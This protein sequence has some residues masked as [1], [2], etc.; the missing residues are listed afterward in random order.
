MLFWTPEAKDCV[1]GRTHSSEAKGSSRGSYHPNREAS[2]VEFTCV[3]RKRFL[4]GSSLLKSFDWSLGH[5][6][7]EGFP[8]SCLFFFNLEA[9]LNWKHAVIGLM[10]PLKIPLKAQAEEPNLKI[11]FCPYAIIKSRVLLRKTILCDCEFADS[12]SFPQ[13]PL[14]PIQTDY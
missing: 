2:Y 5:I 4:K 8:E 10:E 3:E 14:N 6:E 13:T 12:T 7:N 1:S 9:T 11:G